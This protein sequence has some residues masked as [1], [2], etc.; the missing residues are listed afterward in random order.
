MIELPFMGNGEHAYGPL[1]LI[2]SDVCGPLSIN[3]R[4]GFV[5]FITLI[6]NCS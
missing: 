2:H 5:Y 6:D 1:D 3:A 4:G